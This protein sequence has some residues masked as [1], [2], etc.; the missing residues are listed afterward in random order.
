[1]PPCESDEPTRIFNVVVSASI[2]DGTIL[3]EGGT[4]HATQLGR[5]HPSDYLLWNV[6]VVESM[7]C[8]QAARVRSTDTIRCSHC[9][10]AALGRRQDD[11]CNL[12]PPLKERRSTKDNLCEAL[13]LRTECTP[14]PDH[15]RPISHYAF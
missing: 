1:V 2:V 10:E 7:F 5:H 6:A 12:H 13:N 3:G 11:A 15:E 9:T 14:V 8:D 4:L